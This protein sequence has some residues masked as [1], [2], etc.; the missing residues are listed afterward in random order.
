LPLYRLIRPILFRFDPERAHALSL[1]LWRGIGS[2]DALS[3]AAA[4]ALAPRNPRPVELLGLRFPHR[5]GLAAGYDKDGIAWRGLAAAGFGH[6]EVGTVTP[7]PQPGNPRPRVFRL[8]GDRSLINR[9]GFPSAGAR[10]VSPLLETRRSNAAVLGVNLGKNKDT[11]LERA[12]F[13]YED[14][15][16]RLGP[17]ADYLVVNVSSPNTPGLREL[18]R[19]DKLE[20]LLARLVARRDEIAGR[21]ERVLPLLVKLSP[22]LDDTALDEALAAVEATSVDGLIATNTTLD[23]P[24]LRSRRRDEPGGLS[25]AALAARSTAFVRAVHRRTGGR[26]PIVASGGVMGPADARAKLEA[27][28]S[29]VQLYT[30]LVYEGFGLLRRIA[31]EP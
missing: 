28:A 23:R 4:R 8:A 6:V 30:G 15:M 29:L 5:V 3:A 13:D 17:V 25:G 11:P 18:E 12:V 19:R 1:A 14:G 10:R 31:D 26:L 7:R 22:D 2:S 20:P 24:E 16:D 21:A 27:G 9:L